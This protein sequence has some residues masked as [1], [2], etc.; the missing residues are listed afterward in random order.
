MLGDDESFG[1]EYGQI[2]KMLIANLIEKSISSIHPKV[3]ST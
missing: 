2:S 3:S 1:Y